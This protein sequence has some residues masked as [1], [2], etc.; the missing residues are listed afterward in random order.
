VGVDA[1]MNRIYLPLEHVEKFGCRTEDILAHR[2]T[3]QFAELIRYEAE[4]ARAHYRRAQELLPLKWKRELLPARI[5]GEIYL[6]LLAKIEKH[7][8]PVLTK[9][10]KLNLFEKGIATLNAIR[11]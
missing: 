3:P 6:K 1:D 5:M 7:E 11:S 9:K 4:V 8:Y 10:I 2:S